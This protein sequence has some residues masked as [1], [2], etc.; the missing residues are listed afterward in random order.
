MAGQTQ[1]LMNGMLATYPHVQSGK[2]KL[3]AV[4]SAMGVV[5]DFST[6]TVAP[7]LAGTR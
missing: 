4:A 7:A 6:A 3:L 2:L 5:R 1:V